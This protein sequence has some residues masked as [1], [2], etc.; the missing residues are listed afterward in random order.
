MGERVWSLRAG[1]DAL[2]CWQ[3]GSESNRSLPPASPVP[4]GCRQLSVGQLVTARLL[5]PHVCSSKP[6]SAADPAAWLLLAAFFFFFGLFF[7]Q[8]SDAAALFASPPPPC[9][10][11]PIPAAGPGRVGVF[12][13]VLPRG[14][15]WGEEGLLPGRAGCRNFLHIPGLPQPRTPVY[16]AP[17]IPRVASPCPTCLL[18]PRALP[19]CLPASPLL[20]KRPEAFASPGAVASER[21]AAPRSWQGCGWQSPVAQLPPQRLCPARL[22]PASWDAP[23]V[24]PGAPRAGHPSWS[25]RVGQ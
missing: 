4:L 17:G 9:L 25:P 10:S 3:G 19:A 15:Q 12:G 2:K 24:T 23:W 7:P 8:R 1:C 14:A 21:A 11:F 13:A 18:H 20:C 5:S 16:P 22:S 6:C